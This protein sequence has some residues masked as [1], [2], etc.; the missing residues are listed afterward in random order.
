MGCW[1]EKQK[2]EKLI[3]IVCC[4][5]N[6]GR[7]TG[8][9][10]GIRMPFGFFLLRGLLYLNINLFEFL[11]NKEELTWLVKRA[12]FHQ[13][14]M[15]FLL[16]IYVYHACIIYPLV[17]LLRTS[18]VLATH[19]LFCPL[20]VTCKICASFFLLR[21]IVMLLQAINNLKANAAAAKNPNNVKSEPPKELPKTKPEISEGVSRKE[22]EP[23]A[24][25][26]KPRASSILPPNFFDQQETKRPKIG[27]VPLWEDTFL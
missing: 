20:D 26:S 15:S 17:Y 13:I 2:D 21:Q 25:I 12:G 8:D 1:Y 22:L 5:S 27:K 19:L 16:V 4:E 23:S 18:L 24:A 11:A 6:A 7:L 10:G 14:S 9:R 3:V